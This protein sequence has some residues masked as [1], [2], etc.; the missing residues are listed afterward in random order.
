MYRISLVV[1]ARP[2]FVKLF[3]LYYKLKEVNTLESEV[4]HTGQHYDI[5]M[6][7]VFFKEFNLPE[8]DINLE[9]G[10]NSHGKQLGEMLIKLE[11]YYLKNKPDL[12]VVFGDTNSTL[13]GALVGAKMNIPV[14]HVEAG[15]RSFDDTMP[16]E[17]NRII[18][19]RVSSLLFVPDP[20]AYKNLLKE[21]IDKG[22]IFN[23]GNILVDTL[24]MNF[25]KIKR[26]A[27]EILQKEGLE[28]FGYALLTLHR[29]NNVDEKN[30]LLK[31][32]DI[33]DKVSQ[34]INIVFPVHPRTQKAL[35]ELGIGSIKN[36]KMIEPVSYLEFMALLINSRFVMTDSGGVQTESTILNVPCFTMR[37]NTEWVITL[38]KGTNRLVGLNEENILKGIK[39][40]LKE[41]KVSPNV[42]I[43]SCKISYWDGKTSERIVN[44]IINYL[45]G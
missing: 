4:V 5:Q 18:T 45:R 40:I 16:E 38:E 1:G 3:P 24:I 23:V 2:N 21:G 10:S 6:S 8:P 27:S 12:I 37:D 25:E 36:I 39:K 7:D 42:R 17:I 14:A 33:I 9:V 26:I 43:P 29:A 31:I 28:P 15:A 35:K 19:D 41:E 11:D 32:I 13:A 20:I 44:I 34:R 22:K 30:R